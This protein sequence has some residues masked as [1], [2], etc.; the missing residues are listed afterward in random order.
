AKFETGGDGMQELSL[1]WHQLVGVASLA[2]KAWGP[3]A[4]HAPFGILLADEV[5]VGKTAQVMAFIALLQLVHQCEL[6]GQQRPPLLK[7]WP[8]FMGKGKVP[9]APH[10]IIVPNSLVD[11]W[12]RELKC[13][14]KPGAIDIF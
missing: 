1:L 7:T 14:F 6:N 5:G 8:S 3:D 13:F 12:R 2:T 4:R 11:Q 10:A 9:D